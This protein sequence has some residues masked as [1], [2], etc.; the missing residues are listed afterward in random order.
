MPGSIKDKVAIIGVGCTKFGERWDKS[1]EDLLVDATQEAY[2]DAGNISA[3]EI[4]AAWVGIQ[5]WFTGLSGV[6]LADAIKFYG[7]PVTRVE[8]FCA[9]GM[10]SFRNA[11]Y[12]VA[13]GV[14]DVV[15]AS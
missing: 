4:D 10:D 5:Y 14:N 8:N 2:K 11:C 6:T 7:K 15:L 12:A 1:V 9:S 13:S 3:N